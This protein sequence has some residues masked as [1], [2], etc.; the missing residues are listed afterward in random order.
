[1]DADLRYPIGRYRPPLEFAAHDRA[2]R[3]AEIEALPDHLREAVG[4][5]TDSQSDEPYRPGGW[6]VRQLVHHLS[7]SHMN[8]YARFKLALTED[9]P[10]I[11]PYDEGRWASLE[12]SRLLSVESSLKLLEALHERWTLLLRCMAEEDFGRGFNHPEQGRVVTL[13]HSLALYAWHGRHHVAHVT[14][15]RSR[16]GW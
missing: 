7:D 8:A 1:M 2:G 12:D 3:I 5:L 9:E 11:K 10:T 6:T 13:D 4:G 16:K 14:S 15:L